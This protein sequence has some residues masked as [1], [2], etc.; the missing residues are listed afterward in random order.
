MERGGRPFEDRDELI[1]ETNEPSPG[2]AEAGAANTG[3]T[4]A[5]MR[6]VSARRRIP[7][8][9]DSQKHHLKW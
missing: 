4:R 9:I 6:I 8:G 5:V 3:I 2:P 7:Y 1:R